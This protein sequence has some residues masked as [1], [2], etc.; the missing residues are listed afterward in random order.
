MLCVCV[1]DHSL[2]ECILGSFQPHGYS[3]A[4]CILGSFQPHGW[5]ILFTHRRI[6]KLKQHDL[7]LL[8]SLLPSLSLGLQ[9]K[10]ILQVKL[11]A[12]FLYRSSRNLVVCR[13]GRRRSQ[14]LS[15]GECN[16][17]MLQCNHGFAH[18]AILILDNLLVTHSFTLSVHVSSRVGVF[19]ILLVP[20]LA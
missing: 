8:S 1:S 5:D 10:V 20:A 2:A 16:K 17:G 3:F 9:D 13:F 4:E 7:S 11:I 12:P 19:V 6:R 18:Y 14:I 15:S